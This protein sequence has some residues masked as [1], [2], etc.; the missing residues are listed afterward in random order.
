M[1]RNKLFI[2][3]MAIVALVAF[4]S[5]SI[6]AVLPAIKAGAQTAQQKID[7]AIKKQQEIQGQINS[8]NAKKKTSIAEKN[9]IDQ[10]VASLQASVDSINADVTESNNKIAQKQTELEAA[11]AEC[12][13][14]YES[15][16]ER[17][18]LLLEKGSVSYLEIIINSES[19][20]DFLSRVELVKQIAEYDNNK[21]KELQAY[22]AEVEEIKKELEDENKRL[23][24]L[25]AD[26]DSKMAT[27][28]SK[29]AQSQQIIDSLSADIKSFE[30]ALAAQEAAE[31]AAREEIRR[32]T[33]GS[34]NVGAYS[35]GKFTWPSVS[36]YVT[37]DYGMRTHPV[38]GKVRTHAGLDIGASH[39]TNIYAAADGVVLVS[40]WNAGGYGNYVV[41]NHGSGLTTL[42]AHC[43]S[44]N[45][46][47]GQSVKKGQVIAKVGSTGLSTGP[48]LHFEVLVNGSHTN[49]WAYFN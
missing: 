4:L 49:P 17:A 47:A 36:T 32:L 31:A 41:I 27:L 14:Q 13:K 16:C 24:G 26:L 9:V 33:Q 15:Y 42:Y 8:A 21:L 5:V 45:V 48:H 29:Q 20:S 7:E 12:D 3:I 34:S 30:K 38:T 37:S 22:A 19:F 2:K 11:Q 23:K 44:L 6:M 18:K 28:K 39:G 10:E 43:S 25:K 46:S 40:G 1:L 35:G